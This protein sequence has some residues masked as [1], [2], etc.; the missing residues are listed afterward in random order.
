MEG[1]WPPI[2]AV[3]A[4]SSLMAAYGDPSSNAMNQG[5]NPSFNQGANPSMNNNRMNN[6]A[7]TPDYRVNVQ[8]DPNANAQSAYSNQSTYAQKSVNG[9][10]QVLGQIQDRIKGAYKQYNINVTVLKRH[11]YIDRFCKLAT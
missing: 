2:F 1:I 6:N 10:A 8:R 3:A 4:S 11:C 7:T 9:D 5:T